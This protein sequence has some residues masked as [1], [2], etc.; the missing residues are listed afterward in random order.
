[1]I[2]RQA[3]T[4]ACTQWNCPPDQGSTGCGMRKWNNRQLQH[5][6]FRLIALAVISSFSPNVFAQSSTSV[7][8]GLGEKTPIRLLRVSHADLDIDV[9]G[10]LDEKIWIRLD[11]THACFTP[12]VVCMWRST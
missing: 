4:Y 8:I 3:V 9:D 1:M 11:L 6:L 10:R 2:D 12:N 5:I 7:E